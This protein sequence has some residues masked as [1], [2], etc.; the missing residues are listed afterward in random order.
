M[1]YMLEHPSAIM[2]PS[3]GT[4][5]MT[6]K[7]FVDR[8]IGEIDESNQKVKKIG[9]TDDNSEM[10]QAS[11]ALFEYTLPVYRNE[12]SHLAGLY[13]R[14]AEKAEMEAVYKAIADKYLKGYQERADSLIA[15]G[16]PYAKRHDIRVNWDVQTSPSP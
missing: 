5:I 9:E 10:L 3:G 4:A 1:R 16:K 14:G 6:R 13:D 8:R 2:T 15:A 11:I 7:A 12:Y